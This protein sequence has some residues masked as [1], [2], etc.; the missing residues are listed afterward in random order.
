MPVTATPFPIDPMRWY[1]LGQVEY[2]FSIQNL[3]TDF[4]LRKQ[5]DT[6]G[7]IPISTIASF[8]RIRQLTANAYD[9]TL[10][11]DVMALSALVEVYEDYVRLRDRQ[12]V[13]FVLPDAGVSPIGEPREEIASSIDGTQVDDEEDVVFV[14]GRSEDGQTS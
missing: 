11:K 7:W 3:V 6:H 8:N 5:M 4:W 13:P 2:Y 9:T 14:M 10:V 1:L 12:W